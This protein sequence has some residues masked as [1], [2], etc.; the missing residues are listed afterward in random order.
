MKDYIIKLKKNKLINNIIILLNGNI[1]ASII[2]MIN[3]S[4]LVHNIG[5]ELNGVLF[6]AQAYAN[7]FNDLFNFQ[8]FE[9]IIKFVPIYLNKNR[10]KVISYINQGFLL[11]FI[12]ALIAFLVGL[13]ALKPLSIFMKWN[14]EV[15]ICAFI[16]IVV[17]LFKVTGTSIGVLRIFDKFKFTVY[18]TLLECILRFIIYIIGFYINA[19]IVFYAIG[20]LIISIISISVL[21]FLT[22][23]TLKEKGLNK[24]SK[25]YTRI[26]KEFLKF[27][28]FTNIQLTLDM[29][30][31]NLTPFII[32]KYLGLSDIAV[33][34][35][36]EKIGSIVSKITMPISVALSP[37]ISEKIA[38]GNFND[39][40]KTHKKIIKIISLIGTCLIIILY[41]SHNLWIDLFIPQ[42]KTNI[43]ALFLYFIYLIYINCFMAQHSIF[44]YAGYIKYSIIIVLVSNIIYMGILILFSIKYGIIGVVV[45][46]IIQSTMI[47]LFKGI[48]LNL[49]RDSYVII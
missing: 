20:D 34:K 10:N 4:I 49:K 42:T 17:I 1:I 46:R 16:Y 48:I 2:S 22:Y 28:I 30:V 7:L 19:G 38:S 44:I 29:P 27:N 40:I 35:I 8:S 41:I 26:D 6:I 9:S 18:I 3:V 37:N 36:I 32:N 25:K 24:F 21:I 5:L 11:D 13:I 45:A 43:I 15:E 39:A 14:Y 31:R 12:T 47:F 33:Y 23:I